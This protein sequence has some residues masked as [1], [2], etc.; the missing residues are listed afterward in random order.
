[1]KLLFNGRVRENGNLHINNRTQ[2]DKDILAFIGKD[3][4]I[5]IEKK[6]RKR[7][8]DQN[9][10]LHGVVIP[11]CREGFLDV[12]YNY[13]LEETKTDLKRMFA[14]FEKIN[15]TTGEIRE[16]IKDTSDMTTT[17][18]MDFVAHIQQWAAEFLGIII[19]DPG[20]QTEI[21]YEL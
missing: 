21:N 1:M 20:Q 2:F 16:Y 15:E 11:M 18:M 19:P 7:S 14:V 9:A 13:T 4:T 6:K 3:V 8:L 5:K 17:E 12:G 10:F